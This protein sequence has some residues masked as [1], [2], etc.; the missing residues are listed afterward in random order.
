[1][2]KYQW[3]YADWLIPMSTIRSMMLSY[4]FTEEGGEGFLLSRSGKTFVEGKFIRKNEYMIFQE[5]PLGGHEEIQKI[6]YS[7]ASFRLSCD[8]ETGLEIIDPP[9]TIRPF[10]SKMSEMIGLGM[11]VSEHFID[12][13]LWAQEI[14]KR[15][16]KVW[17]IEMQGS[18]IRVSNSSIAKFLIRGELDVRED[19]NSLVQGKQYS[20]NGVKRKVKKKD[21]R[22]ESFMVELKSCG[23]ARFFDGNHTLVYEA[24]RDSFVSLQNNRLK[25]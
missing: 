25:N 5:M 12:P 8:K 14:E 9:R 18:G 15:S 24:V 3:F 13:L 17:V 7:I 23:S 19:W 10:I 16:D 2:T 4:Q 20:L 11:V 6:D 1:M 22:E 21:V